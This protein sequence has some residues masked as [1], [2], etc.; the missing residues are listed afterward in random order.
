[1]TLAKIQVWD[2]LIRT[3]HWLLAAAVLLNWFT[4]SPL[5]LHTWSGYLAAA[6]VASRVM[7]GFIGPENARFGRFVR[8]TS[9]VFDYVAGLV[10]VSSRRY[11]GH[12]P[13]GGA[14]IVA[15]LIMIAATTGTGMASLAAMEGRGPLSAVVE[16][17]PPP[18]TL[19]QRRPSPLIRE[20]HEVLANVTLALV[21]L[22]VAG[23]VLASCVHRENLVMAMITGRKRS[24]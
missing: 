11:V 8:G 23:V 10:R 24:E 19:G 15:L 4:D 1:M 14:M 22:H 7:W 6:L 13:A 21:V 2:P 18:R 20:V 16:R 17:I 12:S 3:I 5:W 9:A